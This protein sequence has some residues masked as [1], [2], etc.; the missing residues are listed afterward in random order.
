[1]NTK[2]VREISGLTQEQIARALDLTLNGWQRKEQN[3]TSIKIKL[4]VTEKIMA[5]LL[6]DAN[7]NKKSVSE[8]IGEMIESKG[9]KK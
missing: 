5:K 8:L 3:N 1:M 2:K 4:K 7:A 9:C 6:R